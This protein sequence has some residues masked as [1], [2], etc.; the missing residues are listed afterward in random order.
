MDKT[1]LLKLALPSWLITP[2]AIAA[3]FLL[4]WPS[5][6][7]VWQAIIPSARSY[8]AE[9]RRLELLKLRL[10]IETLRDKVPNFQVEVPST[11]ELAPPPISN[12]ILS[13]R[14]RFVYGA[15]GAFFG[16]VAPMLFQLPAEYLWNVNVA[17]VIGLTLRVVILVMLGSLL[18]MMLTNLTNKRDAMIYGCVAPLLLQLLIT[19]VQGPRQIQ[20]SN[21]ILQT[22]GIS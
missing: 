17:L 8:S 9:K 21:W 1:D 5:L 18:P 16:A 3:L 15:L 12:E 11:R 13:L 2:A 4:A 14:N 6:R 19:G 22:T 20:Y 10:E 7:D